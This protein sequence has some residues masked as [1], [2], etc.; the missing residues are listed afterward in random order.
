[1]I[2]KQERTGITNK[3]N[4]VVVIIVLTVDHTALAT[5][6]PAALHH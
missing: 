5:V 6:D 1:M 3:K 4:V 2:R